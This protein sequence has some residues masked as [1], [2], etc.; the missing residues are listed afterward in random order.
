MKERPLPKLNYSK[1]CKII[2]CMGN[3]S[4]H[5]GGMTIEISEGWCGSFRRGL[6]Q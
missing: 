2:V 5:D 4:R 1:Q 3:N 6:M